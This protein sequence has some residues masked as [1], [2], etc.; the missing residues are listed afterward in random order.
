MAK[1]DLQPN[2]FVH[3]RRSD[4][5]TVG[6]WQQRLE[7]LEQRH[8]RKRRAMDDAVADYKLIAAAMAEAQDTERKRP[9]GAD[10][11]KQFGQQLERARLRAERERLEYHSARIADLERLTADVSRARDQLIAEVAAVDALNREVGTAC[12]QIRQALWYA[13]IE[14]DSASNYI[15]ISD[16]TRE[17]QLRAARELPEE[18]G[19]GNYYGRGLL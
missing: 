12:E 15:T 10:S 16:A 19:R 5:R 7:E 17:T 13:G 8:I 6:F 2:G 1:D 14:R 4:E 11:Q 18:R 9:T 3:I